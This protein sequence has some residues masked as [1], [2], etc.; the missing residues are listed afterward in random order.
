[1]RPLHTHNFGFMPQ[2]VLYQFSTPFWV[3]SFVFLQLLISSISTSNPLCTF[4][5]L[6]LS[7]LSL[8]LA[9][10]SDGC[11]YNP[12]IFLLD[13]VMCWIFHVTRILTDLALVD[14]SDQQQSAA[15]YKNVRT[16]LNTA[17]K[18]TFKSLK[19]HDK[20]TVSVNNHCTIE[21]FTPVSKLPGSEPLPILVHFHGGGHA[22]GSAVDNLLL[23]VFKLFGDKLV[24]ASVE[25]RLAP[26]HIFPAA[27]DDAISAI[28]FVSKNAK[29][30]GS[31]PQH[32]CISGMSAGGNLAAVALHHASDNNISIK[33][34]YLQ[35]PEMH[36]GESHSVSACLG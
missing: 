7:L 5:Y 15:A 30:L 29:S 19:S 33:H 17:S 6:F 31:S 26:E 32:I 18:L 25:Y 35:I 8:Y 4:L 11:S 2:V 10:R 1:M 22:I 36:I 21:L 27:A 16:L 24:V 34:A 28:E 20:R 13:N 14:L 9:L 3:S 12:K 23:D